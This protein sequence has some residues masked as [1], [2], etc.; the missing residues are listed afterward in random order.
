MVSA[1]LIVLMMS[2]T[3]YE[4]YPIVDVLD[5][6][7]EDIDVYAMRTDSLDMARH[8]GDAGFGGESPIRRLTSQDKKPD[9]ALA[10]DDV[11]RH[12]WYGASSD[13]AYIVVG[14]QKSSGV[15]SYAILRNERFIYND[16]S[17]GE[18]CVAHLTVSLKD[19]VAPYFDRV[20]ANK[21]RDILVEYK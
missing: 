2:C 11:V 20:V 14:I 9:T 1:G 18:L 3:S 7:D 15:G 17:A 10:N 19:G 21:T 8:W 5:F 16:F 13:G 6:G 12:F 4:K